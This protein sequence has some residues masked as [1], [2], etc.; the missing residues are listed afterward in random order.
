LNDRRAFLGGDRSDLA[1]RR[2]HGRALD[3][4]R[5]PG[6]VEERDER[7]A[8]GGWPMVSATLSLGFCRKVSAA[9][10]NRLLVARG[11]GAQRVLDAIAELPEH[12]L[13]ISSGF[14][15]MK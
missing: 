4:G 15:V 14:C 11:E 8:D 6:V 3:D 5:R 1:A 7:F 2:D 9:L 12:L 10:C 13:G